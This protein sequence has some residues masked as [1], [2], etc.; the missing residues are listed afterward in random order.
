MLIG[1]IVISMSKA[2]RNR[3]FYCEKLLSIIQ[4][5][6]MTFYSLRFRKIKAAGFHPNNTLLQLNICLFKPIK[7][8][9]INQY[10][11]KQ[12]NQGACKK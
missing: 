3:Y 8:Q 7:T 5:V 6:E 2:R 4:R 12:N 10:Q 11:R 1:K 9:Y